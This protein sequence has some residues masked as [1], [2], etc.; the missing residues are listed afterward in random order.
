[1]LTSIAAGAS[2]GREP[3]C[4]EF[5]S[6]FVVSSVPTQRQFTLSSLNV[7]RPIEAVFSIAHLGLNAICV[8]GIGWRAERA[9]EGMDKRSERRGW[10]ASKASG[11]R[12]WRAKRAAGGELPS[13]ARLPPVGL[14][15][16]RQ[17]RRIASTTYL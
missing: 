10:L 6:A 2:G 13:A 12:C 17:R 9:A 11:G 14:A 15:S 3:A 1:M 16:S 7:P 8:G 4:S 5:P